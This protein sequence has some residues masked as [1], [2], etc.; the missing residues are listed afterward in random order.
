MAKYSDS[1]YSGAYYG[2]PSRLVLSV[3]PMLATALDYG[4][5]TVSW[6]L[7]TGTF[8][9]IRLIRNNDNFPE[10]HEDGVV[11]WEQTSTSSL[12]G[13]VERNHFVDGTDNYADTNTAND[14]PIKQGQ[15]IY[16]SMW[17]Y[18]SSSGAWIVAG[19]AFCLMPKNR[20]SQDTLFS[21]IPKVYTS[22]DQSPTGNPDTTTFLYTFLKP[23]SFTYD[24]MLTYADLVRP[25]YGQTK[26][27][28]QLLSLQYSNIGLYPERGLPYR[29][30]KKLLREAIKLFSN[31]GT[32]LGLKDYVESLTTYSAT[33]T[34][35]PNLML[36]AQDSTFAGGFGVGRW[37][38]TQGT[39]TSDSSKT[40]PTGTNGVDLT[41]SGNFVTGSVNVSY[42]A[43]TSNVAT[44]T[45]ATPHGYEVGDS[46][47][48]AGVDSTFNGTKTVVSVP[49][50]T[51]FTYAS[52]G[53]DVTQTAT[54][55]TCNGAS[56]MNIGRDNPVLNGTPV[57]AGTSYKFSFYALCTST[58]TVNAYIYW[59]DYKG[60]QIGS[61]VTGSAPL[62]TIGQY[63]LWSQ[64]ATAPTGAVYVGMRIIFT[65]AGNYNIDMVQIAPSATATSY[66]E[67]R[68]VDIYLTAKKINYIPNPNFEVN[69][70]Y[71]STNSTVTTVTDGAPGLPGT[72]ALQ[73]SGTN[74]LVLTTN[75]N[76]NPAY[77]YMPQDAFY[78]FSMYI[79]ASAA[80][81]INMGINATDLQNYQS[82]QTSQT[83]SLTTSYQR[84]QVTM[85]IPSGF[86]PQ[87]TLVLQPFLQGTLSGQSITVDG[88]QLENSYTATDYFDGSLPTVEGA[89]WSGTANASQTYFYQ[90]KTIKVPRLL[91]TLVDWLPLQQPW[92]VR[93]FAGVEGTSASY[94]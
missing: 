92:R 25:S 79:K 62:G 42:K 12:E 53:V 14:L 21:M 7:P 24:S 74:A 78:T 38:T 85:Y 17:I 13:L 45:T 71:W 50:T 86:S 60:A 19:T 18:N 30:Q 32:L 80:V 73:L 89:I 26:T 1:I 28:P 33:I 15:F 91:Q 37:K 63:Q 20:G 84:Y 41:W 64:T 36:D 67:A 76:Q 6:Q 81:T 2:S 90:S 65:V 10:T 51:T 48:V 54:T 93:S 75:A 23:F 56:C 77:V 61:K 66:D 59:Y 44:I 70:Q 11:L 34:P 58:G 57:T 69:S 16:Y 9:R 87:D 47:V 94:T 3:R 5:I 72:K 88:A 29:N 39:L 49:T 46:A 40:A 43:R 55:G 27:P 31:K 82:T 4:L 35:S 52:T 22:A 68:G 83:I 8:T